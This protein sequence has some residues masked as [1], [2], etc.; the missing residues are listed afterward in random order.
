VKLFA[1]ALDSIVSVNVSFAAMRRVVPYAFS[2][3]D[4]TI[5]R[6][7]TNADF[8]ELQYASVST[9]TDSLMRSFGFTKA[10][11]ADSKDYGP[12]TIFS[13]KYNS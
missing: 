7:I 2:L 6:W 3:C 1:G 10:G 8:N 9:K 5:G 11:T 12:V 13:K 4:S